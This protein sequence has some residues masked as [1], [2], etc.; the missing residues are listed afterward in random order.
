MFLY[1]RDKLFLLALLIYLVN[2][3]LLK[4]LVD[5]EA[6]LIHWYL[7][8]LLLIPCALPPVLLVYRSLGIRKNDLPPRPS[9]IVKLVL[10]WGIILELV[11]PNLLG[12]GHGD[13]L[14]V[15]AYAIGGVAAWSYWHF[16]CSKRL[17]E[18]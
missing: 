16:D 5:E 14:D 18:N 7:N 17:C 3:I 10:V 8:D 12:Q 4:P 15:L 9:E 6:T 1:H 11:G 13:P 2:T